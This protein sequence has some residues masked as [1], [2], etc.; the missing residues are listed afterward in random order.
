MLGFAKG[1][2][3]MHANTARGEVPLRLPAVC[4]QPPDPP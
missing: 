1:G 2:L 3:A 4:C